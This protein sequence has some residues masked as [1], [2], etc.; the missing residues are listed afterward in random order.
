MAGKVPNDQRDTLASAFREAIC[1]KANIVPLIHQRMWWCLSEGLEMTDEEDPNGVSVKLPDDR[2]VSMGVNPR[3]LGVARVLGDLGAFKS[4]KSFGAALWTAGFGAVP[5]AKVTLVGSEYSICEPEFNYVIEFLLSAEGMGLKY[6]NLVNRPKQGDMY[7]K[8]KDT[9]AIY[10]AKS[11][12]RKDALKGKEVDVYLY[13]EAYQ[14][15][16]IECFMSVRQNLKARNGFAVF[17]TTPDRPWLKEIHKH[18]HN[19]PEYPEWACTCGVPRS[20][21]A[22]TFDARI[23]A[24]DEKLMTREKFLI[25]HR[26]QLGDFVGKVFPYEEGSNVFTN[27][28]HPDLFPDGHCDFQHL[29]IPANWT[30]VAGADT[31]GFYSG[32]LVAFDP[33]GVAFVVAEFPNYRYVAGQPERIAEITIPGWAA[34]F[35]RESQRISGGGGVTFYADPNSQFKWELRNYGIGLMPGTPTVETRTEIAR[36]YFQ[37]NRV[38]LAPWLEV[39]PF[40]FENAAFPDEASATGAF[41]RIKDRDHTL[42]CFEHV[43]ASRPFGRVD[44]KSKIRT[45]AESLGWKLKSKKGNAHVPAN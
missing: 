28:T 45:F 23:E 6:D 27:R 31:G 7:L 42:D 18:G 38:L 8:L 35:L 29:V 12:E 30:V 13:C 33:N 11:W 41:R 32:L 1:A 16:G 26:G 17:P 4:G 22:V 2:V 24:Q 36:E 10:E 5:G 9:G 3:P 21:N 25:A 34:R 14:L 19:D 40:E 43:V 39:L 37:A 44:P 20:Q 15:P